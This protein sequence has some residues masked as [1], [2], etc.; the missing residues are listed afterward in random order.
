MKPFQKIRDFLGYGERL[1]TAKDTEFLP[2]ALEIIESPPSPA[3]RLLFYMV[4]ALVVMGALWALV[5]TVDEVAVAPGKIIPIGQ[6]KSVQAEDRA[7]VKGIYVKEGQE[8]K[9]GDLLIELDETVPQAEVDRL[10]NEVAYYKLE[11]ERLLAERDNLAFKPSGTEYNLKDVEYQTKLYLSREYE[12][13]TKKASA[14]ATLHQDEASLQSAAIALEKYTELLQY[15]QDKEDRYEHL[16]AE[17]AISA[18]Q[19]IDQQSRSRELAKNIAA[20]HAEIAKAEYA[21]A[22]SR[23]NLANIT[24]E[25]EREITTK[26]VE[27]RKVL[28]SN[29]EDLKKA[30]EKKRLARIVAPVDGR[31]SQL[32]VFTVGGIVTPAQVLMLI[33]PDGTILEVEAWAANKDIGFIQAGQA[34]QVKIETFNFQKYGTIEA[35]VVDVS[36]DAKEDKEKGV[37]QYRIA[38]RL[39]KDMMLVNDKYVPLMPG[40]SATAEIKI[41]EKRIVEFFLDPFKRYQQ[42]ALRER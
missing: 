4:L 23:E 11:I 3:G 32:V 37:L 30:E 20:Q 14:E 21:V 41:K 27:D 12:F 13:K 31:V 5:G 15:A 42:E 2:A 6:V 1:L 40:M 34:A 24:A 17:N 28:Q 25:R 10:K 33:V 39:K 8:V 22:Q 29:V 7:V 9:K 18:V 16:V 35:E 38:L 19:L 36:P 26:L